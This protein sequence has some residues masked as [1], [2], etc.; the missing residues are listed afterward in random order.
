MTRQPKTTYDKYIKKGYE[1]LDLTLTEIAEQL[2]E[3]F[4]KKVHYQVVQ[5]VVKRCGYK[6]KPKKTKLIR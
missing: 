1:V 5:Q 6:R 2:S 3:I 4:N